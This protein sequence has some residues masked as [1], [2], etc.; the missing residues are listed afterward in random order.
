MDEFSYRL[1]HL[2]ECRGIG[3]KTI[4]HLLKLDPSLDRIYSH[5][6]LKETRSLFQS[7]EH[8]NLAFTDL[9]TET[10]RQRIENYASRGI[11]VFTLF[12]NAYPVELK[13]IYQPPW[14]LY[15]IGDISLLHEGRRLA[16]VGSRICTAY[17]E[18]AIYHLFPKLLKNKVVIVSGLADGIDAHAHRVA[19]KLGGRTIAVIAGGFQHIYPQKHISL[20]REMMK[21]QLILS[22][23][24]PHQRPERWQFP[25]R[26][27]IVSGIS[28]GTLIVQAA[29]KSGSLITASCALN[30]GRDVFAVPGNIFC[31][32]SAGTNDLIKQGAKPVM[33][34]EDI[35]EEICYESS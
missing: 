4:Y 15:S 27:R 12:Q 32:L 25:M 19:M 20:A 35:L 34:A 21:N 10:I 8:L 24:A 7:S 17:G 14:V 30:E 11:S 3:W 9:Q 18:R 33:A 23:Y 26:N 22:E 2:H 5:S 16:V 28:R 13:E 1:M 31:Q 29:K 6:F